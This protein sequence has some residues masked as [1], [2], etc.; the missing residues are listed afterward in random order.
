MKPTFKMRG[1]ID[2]PRIR[3]QI[4]NA[5]EKALSLVGFDVRQR[6]QR[7]MSNR[8][9][10]SRPKLWKI[11]TVSTGDSTESTQRD[12]RGRFKKG[13]GK[14][15]SGGQS[16]LVAMV[17][18]VPK[19]DRVTSWK[20]KRNPTG[21][22]RRDI[23]WDY[24]RSRESVAI[25]PSDNPALNKLHEF[26]ASTTFHF[27]PTG[28]GP[29]RSRKYPGAVFGTLSNKRKPDSIYSFSRRVKGRGYMKIG[30]QKSMKRIPQRFRDTIKGP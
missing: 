23:D 8:A 24:S 11:A 18:Q 2:V 9:P 29:K 5:N 27:T 26:G 3:R 4:R 10:L 16:T 14:R 13:S 22:L 12:S 7:E 30:L 1:R 19:P 25:G 15:T 28:G 6:T 21:F 17:Y 20:T